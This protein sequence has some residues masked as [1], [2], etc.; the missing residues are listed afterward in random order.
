[1][2][3]T[4]HRRPLVQALDRQRRIEDWSGPTVVALGSSRSRR[5]DGSAR[6]RL[7]LDTGLCV[8]G[9]PNLPSSQSGRVP[10]MRLTEENTMC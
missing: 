10:E 2:G 1:M 7:P 8:E 3:D 6:S 4:Q 9:L 5:S